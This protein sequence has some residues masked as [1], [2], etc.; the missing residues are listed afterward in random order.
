MKYTI[1]PV[2][3]FSFSFLALFGW[4]KQNDVIKAEE[5]VLADS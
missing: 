2:F 3:L 1:L 5:I 4:G